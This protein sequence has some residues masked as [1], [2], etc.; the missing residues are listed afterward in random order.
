MNICSH[1]FILIFVPIVIITY[2]NAY[3]VKGAIASKYELLAV[4][5]FF[6]VSTSIQAFALL[7]IE[8]FVTY[9]LSSRA[10]HYAKKNIQHIDKK[11]LM[12]TFAITMQ[13]AV[14]LVFKYFNF[15]ISTINPI[16]HTEISTLNLLVPLGI[17]FF[18]FQQIA[19][20]VDMYRGEIEEVNVV[21]YLI[22]SFLF[23][24]ISS[25]PIIYYNELITQLN[26]ED[27]YRANYENLYRGLIL[28]FI[29]L[30][31]KIL[32]AN[33]FA[34]AVNAG[35]E[36]LYSYGTLNAMIISLCYTFQIYFDFSGYCDMGLG[37]ARML[38]IDLPL[39]FNSPYK[40]F[41]IAEF[42]DRW[43]ITLTRFF[44]KYVYIPLGGSRK[45]KIRTYI[46]IF[47]IF[48]L[49]GLWHGADMKFI[50]WGVL[51][52]L[53][54]IAYRMFRKCIDKWHPAFN[55]IFTFSFVNLAWVYFGAPSRAMAN[56]LISKIVMYS[57][58]AINTD[59]S[60]QFIGKGVGFIASLAGIDVAER[61]PNILMVLYLFG[62]FF[63]ILCCRNSYEYTNECEIK[64]SHALAIAFLAI[65]SICSLT[66][67]ISFVY[68]YF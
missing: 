38:N 50:I 54:M 32:V 30:C 16:L 58:G 31:K 66:G 18:T 29:G 63:V 37:V 6:Y 44:T 49:S 2:Y 60:A 59:V 12:L 22:F 64:L 23:I 36:D 46:N 57:P 14:L 4:S 19:F 45:G 51:H 40:A 17:S 10:S 43:H 3:R 28:F 52:G 61:F 56:T 33:V 25:G 26:R 67:T 27:N 55:W 65:L 42:W 35:Y 24:T 15:F 8:A 47:I 39:N 53:M 11:K 48:F 68:Q 34:N 5:M 13:L 21:D 7:L 62:A 20:S 9:W 41:T 1:Q